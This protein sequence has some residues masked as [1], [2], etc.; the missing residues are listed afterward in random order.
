MVIISISPRAGLPESA[1]AGWLPHLSPQFSDAVVSIVGHNSDRR[2][3]LQ[4]PLFPPRS[5]RS[6]A[7][8]AADHLSCSSLIKPQEFARLASKRRCGHRLSCIPAKDV[9]LWGVLMAPK[10]S[11]SRHNLATCIIRFISGFG[12]VT[13]SHARACMSVR[14]QCLEGP[15]MVGPSRQEP[16]PRVSISS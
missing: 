1:S 5:R 14:P 11:R 16:A 6:K 7:A 4:T 13:D 15:G 8:D 10:A 9:R 12:V 2:L 3:M